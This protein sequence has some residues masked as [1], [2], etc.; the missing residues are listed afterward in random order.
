MV[1]RKQPSKGV[2]PKL[3]CSG[4]PQLHPWHGK[5]ELHVL[6]S[7][8]HDPEEHGMLSLSVSRRYVDCGS[9][10]LRAKGMLPEQIGA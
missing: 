5:V 10:H 6:H 4:T 1:L 3:H 9:P 2:L 8:D 7:P